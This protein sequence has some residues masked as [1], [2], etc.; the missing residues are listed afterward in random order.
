MGNLSGSM[1]CGSAGRWGRRAFQ[2]SSKLMPHFTPQ[3]GDLSGVRGG[4]AKAATLEEDIKAKAEKDKKSAIDAISR[5]H[6]HEMA[7]AQKEAQ[8]AAQIAESTIANLK[9]IVAGQKGEI[10]A[11]KAQVNNATQKNTELAQSALESASRSYALNA[12][13]Q[14]SGE[15]G[16]TTR[17]K[18]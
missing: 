13:M 18:N 6:K 17:R 16:S 1:G 14:Q 11:L 3:N 2:S 15:N 9:L 4:E 10:E 12:V 8:T 5:Q 7:L